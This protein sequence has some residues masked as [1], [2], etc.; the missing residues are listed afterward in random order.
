MCM[1]VQKGWVKIRSVH[2]ETIHVCV[3]VCWCVGVGLF[4]LS[5][6]IMVEG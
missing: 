2:G 6:M 1:C 4:V 5:E 3:C